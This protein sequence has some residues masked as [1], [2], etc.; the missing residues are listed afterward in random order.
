[1]HYTRPE[2]HS[3]ST[4]VQRHALPVRSPAGSS[5]H[6]A[7]STSEIGFNGN[8]VRSPDGSGAIRTRRGI[9][10]ASRSDE[11]APV[12]TSPPLE[13]AARPSYFSPY[14]RPGNAPAPR[15]HAAFAPP[16]SNVRRPGTSGASFENGY[17]G[18]QFTAEH[19]YQ[20]P[21]MP[22]AHPR[23][24]SLPHTHPYSAPAI[25]P[26]PLATTPFYQPP[27]PPHSQHSNGSETQNGGVND[28]AGIT[29]Q[30][31]GNNNVDAAPF[32]Q[33]DYSTTVPDTQWL[34][35]IPASTSS[36]QSQSA[37]PYPA[38]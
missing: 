13:G 7:Y 26:P 14:S 10:G 6:R 23:S 12:S 25:P 3:F 21:G 32:R 30:Y 4:P 19:P 20:P 2:S 16:L 31:G 8:A 38:G 37:Y 17:S 5:H 18:G 1:M 36:L 15:Q 34:P 24:H 33:I 35:S 9:N 27:P 29:A 22:I 28:T 11:S